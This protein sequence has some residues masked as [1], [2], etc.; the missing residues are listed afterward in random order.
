M[1]KLFLMALLT[2]C[3][4]TLGFGGGGG[5][6]ASDQATA[7]QTGTV[8]LRWALW[9]W[10]AVTYYKPLL[11]AYKVKNPNVNIEWI[12][13]GYT[14]YGTAIATQLAGDSKIDIVTIGDIPTYAN[15]TKVGHLENLNDYV[16]R[17]GMDLN[18]FS[19]LTDELKINGGVYA[20][21][22]RS[23]FWVTYY[24]KDLFDAAGVPYPTNDM[25]VQQYLEL[26]AKVTRGRGS[27]KVYGAHYHT[28]RST[29]QLFGILD[30][31]HGIL[32]GKYDFL[33]PYYDMALKAQD[34]GIVMDYATLKAT[35]THYSGVFYNN[36]LAMIHM[37][38]WWAP[39]IIDK[40]KI[41]E[42]RCNNWGIVKFP[43]PEGVAPGTTLGTITSVGVNARSA[44]KEAAWDFVRFMAGTEGAQIVAESGTFPAAK[45]DSIVAAISRQPGF[46]QDENSKKALITVRS[47][48]EMPISDISA[49]AEVILNNVHDAVMTK[50]QTVEDGIAQLNKEIPTLIK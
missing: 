25:T 12:D 41:G 3:V 2:L 28:W 6:K 30:G 7:Q 43:H 21:P 23:D 40:L 17:S 11:E 14:D 33:K 32:D 13:L 24:N 27:E 34:D 38:T 37:G 8:N 20:L 47:Y 19:G 45:N 4:I 39:T 42:A 46:P 50:N 35:N 5:Q 29:V 15:L 18:I 36:Q 48:L 22:F 44:N 26:A 16:K 49:Q 31:K 10:D 9:D 1:K